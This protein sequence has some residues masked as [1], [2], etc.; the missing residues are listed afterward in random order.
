MTVKPT[1][2]EDGDR[3]ADK[4]TGPIA[5]PRQRA[6]DA[7]PDDSRRPGGRPTTSQDPNR[8][9]Q[10]QWDPQQGQWV[11]PGEQSAHGGLQQGQC[12]QQGYEQQAQHG[13]P[14]GPQQPTQGYGQP[15]GQWPPQQPAQ[16]PAS[17]G[18]KWPWIVGGIVAL[19][20]IGSMVNG[21]G[22]TPTTTTSG[23]SGG[24][25]LSQ[26]LPPINSSSPPTQQPTTTTSSSPP[27]PLRTYSGTGDDVVRLDKP[28]GAAI[29]TFSCPRCTSNTIVNGDGSNYGLVNA[30]GPYSGRR[31][32]DERGNT[33]TTQLAIRAHGNWTLTISGLDQATRAS[34][35]VSGTGD[36][37]VLL[38]ANST[39]AA[40]TNRG[41][42]NFIVTT[43]SSVGDIDLP[44]N[45]IGSYS[46]TVP[47]AG[48]ALIE[49]QS[50]GSW[51]ITPR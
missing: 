15:P 48:P 6:P 34:G 36:D 22:R 4:P 2:L 19:V 11:L 12:V 18:R 50:S 10:P 9:P 3:G 28:T 45:E 8:P 46:G 41:Q 24:Q 27:I 31:W 14:Q 39:T 16:A 44:V 32:I 21:G 42:S 38:N 35:P 30:I 7:H 26:T 40:L 49:V 1:E 51:T 5:I 37:V 25:P 43:I 17:R 47:L 20:V 13:Q 29:M 33:L 23:V